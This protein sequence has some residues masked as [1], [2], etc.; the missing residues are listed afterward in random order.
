MNK[1]YRR[2]KVKKWDEFQNRYVPLISDQKYEE[3]LIPLFNLVGFID[4]I[5]HMNPIIVT[6]D[7]HAT[8]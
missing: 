3:Q 5:S 4:C 6:G 7:W 2:H 8:I 1:N